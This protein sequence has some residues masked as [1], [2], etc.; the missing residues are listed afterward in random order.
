LK[1]RQRTKDPR[2]DDDKADI[3]LLVQ[4]VLSEIA[5]SWLII[6]DNIDNI[7]I[8]YVDISRLVDYLLFN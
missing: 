3:K 5:S 6:L 2:I 7:S 8:L 1:K 4:S